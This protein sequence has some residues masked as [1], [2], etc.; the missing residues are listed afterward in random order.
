MA[1]RGSRG[2]Q[3]FSGLAGGRDIGHIT[4]GKEQRLFRKRM[5][6]DYDFV[7]FL[8]GDWDT[9]FRRYLL[10]VLANKRPM[11]KVLC[12]DRPVCLVST[13]MRDPARWIKQVAGRDRLRKLGENLFVYR[14]WVFVHDHV[15]AK[16][17]VVQVSNMMWV[18]RQVLS[19]MAS[20]GLRKEHLITWIF[21]P[22]QEEYMGLV[23]E[24]LSIYEC[25][26]EYGS[27]DEVRFFR[28]HDEIRAREKRILG[29]ADITFVVSEALY[30]SKCQLSRNIHIVPNGVDFKHFSPVYDERTTVAKDMVN[31]SKPVI[32]YLGNLTARIDFGLLCDLADIHPEWVIV[33]I[34]GKNAPIRDKN[35][36]R[37]LD[38]LEQRD[39]VHFVGPKPYEDLTRYLKAFDVCLLPYV[40]DDP[41]NINCSPLKLYEYLA[42][43]KPIVSTDL[44]AVRPFNGLVSI[45][46]D[47]EDFER[48]V[49]Q[50]LDER[51]GELRKLRLAAAQENSWERRAETVLEI[52]KASLRAG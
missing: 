21:D 10:R 45:A 39:N 25:Y 22:F 37:Y 33:L 44:P 24:R 27:W 5:M 48:K 34:G 9:F 15:A 4:Q 8:S 26:D 14:P 17:P 38:E 46:R 42:T 20:L 49:T 16:L 11:S 35:T 23:G 2:V 36:R 43:G 47:V 41:F 12:V 29:K 50:A 28:T 7:I 52:I 6:S 18:R 30:E 40:V 13:P 19:V 3:H 31:V 1:E 32:G 51:D